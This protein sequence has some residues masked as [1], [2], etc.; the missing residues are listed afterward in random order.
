MQQLSACLIAA[1]TG[2]ITGSVQSYIFSR[3]PSQLKTFSAHLAD[4][5][6]HL[7]VATMVMLVVCAILGCFQNWPDMLLW[8]P[9]TFIV[10]WLGGNAYRGVALN[11]CTAQAERLAAAVHLSLS[12]RPAP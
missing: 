7:L 3:H 10:S 6:L 11:D 12:A 9:G 8:M 5:R 4:L 1:V 2:A